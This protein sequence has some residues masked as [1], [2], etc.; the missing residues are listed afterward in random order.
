MSGSPVYKDG[1][2]RDAK[3]WQAPSSGR[4]LNM[5]APPHRGLD[6]APLSDG[7]TQ[8]VLISGLDQRCLSEMPSYGIFKCDPS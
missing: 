2:V 5:D 3:P 7:G 1:L 4:P 6:D 8:P